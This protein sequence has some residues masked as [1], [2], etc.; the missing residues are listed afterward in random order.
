M[1]FRARRRPSTMKA[2]I[3]MSPRDLTVDVLDVSEVGLR[4]GVKGAFTIGQ[5]V[6]LVTPRLQLQGVVMWVT[7][8]EIGLKLDHK[9]SPSQMTELSGL[10]W[11]M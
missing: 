10:S 3:R 7:E 6:M 4:L 1:F 11:G 5:S 9:L 8:K 2:S